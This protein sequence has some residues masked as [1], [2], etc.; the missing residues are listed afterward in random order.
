MVKKGKIVEIFSK[1]LYADDP[2]EYKIFFRDFDSLREMTLPDF[3]KESEHFQTIPMSR[4]K[5]I[6]KK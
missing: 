3:V 5:L 2:K 6:K 4:I 1:A